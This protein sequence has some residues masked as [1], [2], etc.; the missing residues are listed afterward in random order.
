[1]SGQMWWAS[2][3]SKASACNSISRADYLHIMQSCRVGLARPLPPM[4]KPPTWRVIAAVRG[5]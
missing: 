5:R 3:A 2:V 1:M 4:D